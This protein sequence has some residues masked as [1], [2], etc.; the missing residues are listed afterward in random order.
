MATMWRWILL[1]AAACVL[2]SVGAGMSGP[3]KGQR[4]QPRDEGPDH[5]RGRLEPGVAYV[6]REAF[7]GNQRACVMVEGDHK[8]VMNLKV[9]VKDLKGK[10]VAEDAGPGD[11]VAVSWYPPR[12]QDYIISIMSDNKEIMNWID[13]VVK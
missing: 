12:T 1:A 2:L 5:K 9:T 3:V 11:F 6:F 10:V 13:V 8:P 7:Y 4:R